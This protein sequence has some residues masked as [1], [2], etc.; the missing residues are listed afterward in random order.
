MM[1][2]QYDGGVKWEIYGP[3]LKSVNDLQDGFHHPVN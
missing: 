2:G 1:L 3:R